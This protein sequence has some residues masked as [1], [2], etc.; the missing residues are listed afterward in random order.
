MQNINNYR[1]ISIPIFFSKVFERIMYNH[2]ID[3]M[4]QH[5][6]ISKFQFGFRRKH[7]TQH[8][9]I[10]LVNNILSSLDSNNIVIGIFLDLKNAFDTVNHKILLDKL[11]AYGIRGNIYKWFVSYLSDRTQYVIFEGR[12][13]DV[14]DIKCGVPQGS[15]LGPLLF[16]IYINEICHISDLLFKIVYADDTCV[17]INGQDIGKLVEIL[18]TELEKINSWLKANKLSLNAQKTYYIVFHRAKLKQNYNAIMINNESLSEV[19]SVKYLGLIIDHRLKWT[20]HI[21]YTRNKISRGIGIINK[22]KPF[23]NKKALLDLYYAFIYPYLSYC[24]E[25]WGN[26]EDT[27]LRPLCLLQNKII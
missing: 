15:I 16:I 24:V 5:E 26:T 10:C 19:K 1:P 17:L 11:Y 21:S 9:A 23:L 20:D 8:A 14:L 13:S 4:D 3:F 12:K 27:H 6:T 18:N 7:S 22:A 25:V 2:I